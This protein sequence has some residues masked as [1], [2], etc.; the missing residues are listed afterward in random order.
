MGGSHSTRPKT[1][2]LACLVHN[3]LSNTPYKGMMAIKFASNFKK[4]N[5][6]V[7][8]DSFHPWSASNRNYFTKFFK[9]PIE[10][11]PPPEKTVVGPL[12]PKII[13]K[14]LTSA[15]EGHRSLWHWQREMG[16]RDKSGS[17]RMAGGP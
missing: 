1:L 13:V 10:E 17:G 14:T 8:E 4:V 11:M 5:V 15:R 9:I 16:S 12:L 2:I 3:F 7:K 6:H